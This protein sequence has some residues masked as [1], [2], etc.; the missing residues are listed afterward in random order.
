M[1]VADYVEEAELHCDQ[2]KSA[3]FGADAN[4]WV[5]G[6]HCILSILNRKWVWLIMSRRRSYAVIGPNLQKF[7]CGR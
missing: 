3:Y 6:K 7:L 5:D 1:G 2:S 4:G